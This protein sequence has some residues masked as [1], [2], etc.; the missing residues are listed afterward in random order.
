MVFDTADIIKMLDDVLA[1]YEEY[2]KTVRHLEMS[3]KEEEKLLES[4]WE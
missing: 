3:M 2:K 4:G 1:E